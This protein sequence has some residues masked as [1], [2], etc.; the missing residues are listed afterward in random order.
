MKAA[1]CWVLLTGVWYPCFKPCSF[2]LNNESEWIFTSMFFPAWW[3]SC[4]LTQKAHGPWWKKS[5][6]EIFYFRAFCDGSRFMAVQASGTGSLHDVAWGTETRRLACILAAVGR[7]SQILNK[8]REV[9]LQEF[10]GHVQLLWQFIRL[11]SSEFGALS[12]QQFVGHGRF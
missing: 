7:A 6:R 12:L 9:A 3:N 5:P 1:K 4:S 11:A 8:C 10:T 2:F